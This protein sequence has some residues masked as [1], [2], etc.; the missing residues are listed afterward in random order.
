MAVEI[1][2]YRYDPAYPVDEHRSVPAGISSSS[3]API[4][5]GQPLHREAPTHM[6]FGTGA[7]VNPRESSDATRGQ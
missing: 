6:T 3:T 5:I 2:G 4:G 1:F 7:D